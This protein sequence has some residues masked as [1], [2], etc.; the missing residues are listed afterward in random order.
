MPINLSPDERASLERFVH[1][2]KPTKRQKAKALL[3]L[4]AGE[5]ADV[6]AMRVG[7]PK[8]VVTELAVQFAERGLAGVGSVRR[9][10]V[11]VTLIQAGIGA[12]KYRLP[13][14]S[15]LDDL[16]KWAGASINE[17][18]VFVDE[19]GPERSPVLRDG[20]TVIITPPPKNAASGEPPHTSV[21]SLQ[22]D[23]IFEEYRAILKA[24]RRSCA[25]EEGPVE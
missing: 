6:V 8:E 15:T 3:G 16:L 1:P 21:P 17:Q 13:K 19:I 23:A 7:I 20:A 10:E 24:R 14:G 11:V 2:C 9:P 22:D 18:S 12:Q 25:P 4:A 5:S